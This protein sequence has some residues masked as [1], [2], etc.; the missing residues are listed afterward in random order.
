M[1]LS[2]HPLVFRCPRSGVDVITGIRIRKGD[3]AYLPAMTFAIRCPCCND[4]HEYSGS[5]S[6][7]LRCAAA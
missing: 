7:R 1:Y 5:Q 2:R 4:M 3:E 6:R